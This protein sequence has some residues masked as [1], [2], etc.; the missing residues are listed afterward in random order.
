MKICLVSPA[1]GRFAVTR[2]T[3]AQRRWLCDELA[4]R[5]HEAECVVIADDENLEIAAEYGFATVEM[6]NGDLGAKFNA[7]YAWG[8]EWGAET[9]VHIGSDDWCAPSVFDVLDVLNLALAPEPVWEPNMVKVW[10]R[11][12]M[13]V[14]QRSI[15]L[16]NLPTGEVQRCKA[17]GRYGC[18]PWLLPRIVLE[19]EGF[20]P[21]KE[22]GLRRG[23]DGALVRGLRMRPNWVFQDPDEDTVVD[24]KSA[25][26]LTAF[27]M[28]KQNLG[29]GPVETTDVL[30]GTYPDALV[31]M[32]AEACAEAVAA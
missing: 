32:A 27:D 5:G 28:L 26:N 18:I 2:L 19:N 3:L 12:P 13:L 14:S 25:T 8:G 29:Y 23:I 1:W 7:G 24:F 21:I 16:V 30:R 15:T 20:E 22:R 4:L 9:F 6:R 10:R 31:D 11:A 17:I